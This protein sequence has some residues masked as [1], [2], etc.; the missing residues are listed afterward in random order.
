VAQSLSRLLQ[1]PPRRPNGSSVP[2]HKLV[3]R[4]MAAAV[5]V[6]FHKL[7]FSGL[8]LA[9]GDTLNYFYPYWR[10]AASALSAG[11]VPLWNPSLFMGAPMLANSQVGLLYPLNWPLWLLL[12]TPYAVSAS[13]VLHLIIAGA[14]V[15]M[16]GRRTLGLEP[17]AAT[18]AAVLFALGGYLTAQV[19]HINQLQG[20]AWMPWVFAAASPLPQQRPGSCQTA[21]R[22]ACLGLLFGLQL[23]A[24][25]TQTPFITGVGLVIWLPAVIR[26]AGLRSPRAAAAA[27]WPYAAGPVLAVFLA[28]AQ[29]VPSSELAQHSVRQGG[30]P[31]NEAMSF[32]LHPLVL[33]R[34]LLPTYGD[35]LFTEYVAF[36][37]LT[38]LLL[39]AAGAWSWRSRPSTRAWLVVALLGLFLSLGLFNPLY[40][41]LVAL[42]GFGHFRAPARWLALYALG[43]ALLAGQ[44]WQSLRAGGGDS[45][46]F[47]MVRRPFQAGIVA[48]VLLAAW[49]Y[50]SGA[51]SNFLPLGAEVSAVVPNS[52]TLLTWTAELGL[53]GLL[54]LAAYRTSAIRPAV[55][56]I[57]ATLAVAGLYLGSRDL[58]Y[59][60]PTTS[61][62]YFDLRPAAARLQAEMPCKPFS[63]CNQPAPRVLSLSETFF[64]LGDQ[65]E[66]DAIYRDQLSEE[67]LYDYTIAIK[68]K[69]IVAPNLPLVYDLASVDGFDGGILPLA[70]YSQLMTLLLPGGQLTTDGRLR[71]YL[72]DL[73]EDRWLDLFNARYVITDKIGDLWREGVF[74]DQQHSVV[75]GPRNRAIEVG[76]LPYFEATGAW[77]LASGEPG[78]VTITVGGGRPRSYSPVAIGDGL[79]AVEWPE[80]AVPTSIHVSAC[81]A[82]Q[83][84]FSGCEGEWAVEAISLVD[85]RDGTFMPLVLGQYRLIHSGDVKIYENLD[86]QPRAFVVHDWLEIGAV[87]EALLL[88][89]DQTF[90]PRLSAVVVGSGLPE[91]PG[92]GTAET[93]ITVY[94]PDRVAI[95]TSSSTPGLLV[96][97]DAFYPGWRAT[98]DGAP[99]AIYQTNRLFRGIFVGAGQHEVEFTY[100][101]AS[102]FLGALMSGLGLLLTAMLLFGGQRRTRGQG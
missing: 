76:Y 79:Y 85:D 58:P 91:P 45:L 98:V 92:A 63:P 68:Q 31:A 53:F 77:I 56:P 24:G 15:Y 28:G 83:T 8:I 9:R 6:F 82:G 54:A 47:S 13:I 64:E 89:A 46:Q 80:P 14:G 7:S 62:A 52:Q 88:M 11:R 30:L 42:P 26:R 20:L 43:A 34:A 23:L 16:A 100:R 78:A 87:D 18:L 65:S 69:E 49:S 50:L 55:A 36:L 35:E 17:A 37:P 81:G 57:L 102:V 61:Q 32:S 1:R 95:R 19:E 101:P 94:R 71:E 39:A 86:V 41:L 48:L 33:G 90:Q 12:D 3:A 2:S 72:E 75:L 38:G 51:L 70:A 97:T 4:F 29:V 93:E 5:L 25:H 22:A 66:I 21:R 74:F 44:G 60:R 99:A 73:P 40:H 59:N 67:A 96:L 84:D 10:A 27:L